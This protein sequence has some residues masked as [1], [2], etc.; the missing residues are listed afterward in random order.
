M[1]KVLE[2]SR[3]GFY[4]WVRRDESARTRADRDGRMRSERST[5]R[6]VVRAALR[7]RATLPTECDEALA[8]LGRKEVSVV[9]NQR[10]E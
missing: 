10:R 9:K 3:S 6:A 1:C 7:A 2:V 4:A 5:R 8:P